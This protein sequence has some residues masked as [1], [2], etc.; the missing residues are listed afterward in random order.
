ML[1]DLSSKLIKFTECYFEAAETWI[2][3]SQAVVLSS[4]GTHARGSK[5]TVIPQVHLK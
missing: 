2:A 3:H 4:G 1:L 5:R